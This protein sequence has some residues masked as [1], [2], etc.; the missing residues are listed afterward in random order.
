MP[1]GEILAA[2]RARVGSPVKLRYIGPMADDG[3]ITIQL[4][5]RTAQQ[6]AQRA[7]EE[8]V[9]PEQYAAEV[10]ADIVSV[11]F[12]APPPGFLVPEEELRASLE[13]QMR[14]I[15]NGEAKLIPHEEV[16]AEVRAIIEAAK[17][18]KA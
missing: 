15:D 13:E 9:S 12:D 4:D 17:A 18:R 11:D 1:C 7:Q 5:P 14:Q 3:K 6:L 16:M 8:G 10:V 2:T